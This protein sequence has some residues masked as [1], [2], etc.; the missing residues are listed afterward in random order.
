MN[1]VPYQKLAA[2]LE[3]P[4]SFLWEHL[5]GCIHILAASHD[6]AADLLRRFK[7]FLE[8]T[9]ISEM[10]EIYTRT[11]DLQPLCFP[12]VGY[13][14]F[15]EDTRRGMFMVKLKERYRF[16]DFSPGNEL[17]DHLA[18][19]LRFLA[20]LEEGEESGELV[21]ACIIPSLEKM[22]RGFGDRENAYR[23]VME[24]LLAV[25]QEKGIR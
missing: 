20:R 18:V 1:E 14:L 22:I 13:H 7:S 21:R 15:G 16:Y 6:G 9:P 3:Y 25:T 23:L 8:Q 4:T 24:A 5:E 11:F 10:E 2:I 19:M 17:P 12:Y